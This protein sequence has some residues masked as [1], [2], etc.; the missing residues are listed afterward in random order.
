MTK[1]WYRI[2]EMW[3]VLGLLLSA[4]GGSGALIAAAL[5]YPDAVVVD[6]SVA[7]PSLKPAH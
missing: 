4:V 2:P 7:H 3:L 6:A 1:P 5:D